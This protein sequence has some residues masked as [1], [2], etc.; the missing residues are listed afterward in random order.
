MSLLAL[1]TELLE[2]IVIITDRRTIRLTC[3]TLCDVATP[4]VFEHI[5]IDFTKIEMHKSRAIRF[6]KELSHGRRLARFVR[7]LYFITSNG[8]DKPKF[9]LRDAL[10]LLK[11]KETFFERVGKLILAAVPHMQGLQQFH[12]KDP[13]RARMCSEIMDQVIQSLSNHPHLHFVSVSAD[14]INHDIHCA[15]FRGLTHL[16]IAGDGPLDYAPAIIANSPNL[17]SLKVFSSRRDSASPPHFPVLSLFSAF[18]EGTHSSVQ[19]VTLGG[20]Y[21]SLEPSA[22]PALIPH[23]RNLSE[24]V[25]P[26]GFDVPDEFWSALLDAQVYL[27]NATSYYAR[28]TQSFLEYLGGYHG[29]KVLHLCLARVYTDDAP[30]K[31]HSRFFRRHIIPAHSSSL[32]SVLVQPEYAGFWCFDVRMLKAL[33]LCTNL[34]H[35]GISVDEQRAQVEHDE[36]VITKLLENVQHWHHLEQLEIGAAISTDPMVHSLSPAHVPLKR[37][38][39][40]HIV[41]CAMKFQCTDPTPQM[42]KLQIDTDFIS[43]IQ[44]RLCQWEPKSQIYNFV[45]PCVGGAT[46]GGREARPILQKIEGDSVTFKYVLP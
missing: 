21:L 1:P 10:S 8:T 12:W 11:N 34:I 29:L 14:G 37:D 2:K 22:V 4:L 9:S 32:T 24:F 6:L 30:D 5:S 33:L 17:F 16:R 15:P 35:I 38:V 25:L 31:F 45:P 18:A 36:N 26:V 44:L 40:V 7:S 39:C 20:D 43:D 41:N 28:L 42:L 23:F 46:L 27:R 19:A 3:K 13:D